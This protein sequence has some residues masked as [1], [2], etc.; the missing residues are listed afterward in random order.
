MVRSVSL[1][2]GKVPPTVAAQEIPELGLRCILR[3]SK[4]FQRPAGDLILPTSDHTRPIG[5]QHPPLF[6]DFS[7]QLPPF[8]CDTILVH[9]DLPLIMMR[10]AKPG[11][12]RTKRF[13][14]LISVS[15]AIVKC[16]LPNDR[17]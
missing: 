10:P 4:S 15:N 17:V 13:G 6:L 12:Y 2:A 5:G 7:A 1:P 16:I 11:I 3:D 8:A 9:V 14:M